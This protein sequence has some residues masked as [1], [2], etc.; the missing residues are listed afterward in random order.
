M[1]SAGQLRAARALLR[2]E[3]AT[4]AGRAKISVETIKRLERLEGPL[5]AVKVSTIEAIQTAF[6]AAGVE[7]I[8][9]VEGVRGPGVCLKWGI[10]SAKL[11]AASGEDQAGQGEGG[12]SANSCEWADEDE[13][14]ISLPPLSWTCQDREAQIEHWRENSEKWAALHEVSRQALLQAMGVSALPSE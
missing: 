1:L 12:L 4:V 6:E 2:W 11:E 5:K 7:F 9:P 13:P 3:Q 10:E 8:N 14:I